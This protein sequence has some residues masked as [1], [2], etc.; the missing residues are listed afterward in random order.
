MD[1]E[2]SRGLSVGLRV[3]GRETVLKILGM[4]CATC[5]L[6]VQKALLSVRG[7]KWAEASL[8]SN[9]AR[10][11][12][13]PEVLDYGELLRAVRRAGYDVYRESAYFVVDFRPEEAESVERR[14]GGWGVFYARAN[15]ATGV[16]YV[17]YNPLEVGADVVVKRLEEAGYRV[18]EVR[19]GGVEVDVDRRVAELEAADLRR[20]LLPAAAA[21]A[22]LVPMMV[23]VELVPPLVQMALAAL[24]QF[25]SGWRFISGA[26]RAFR[27]GTANMDTLVTL[28]TLSAFL[29]SVYAVFAG[30][31]TFFEASALVITFVLAGRYLES[32]MKLRSGDAV[33]RLA[34]L[35]P[36]RARVR[37]GGG[38]VEVDAAEVRPGEVVEVREGERLPV[39][40]YVDEGVG[41]VDESAFT[42]EPLPVEKGP[43]DLVLAGTTLV[44]G[45]LL[46]RATRSGEATYLAEVVKLVRQA[47]NARLPIQNF[48]DRVSGVFTWVVM[49]VASATFVGWLLAGAPVWRAL[50]FAVAVLVVACPCALGLAT[51]LAVVVGIG[52]A[53]ERG[54]LVKNVE[55]V[56]RALGARYVAFDKTGT[57]TVGAPRVVKY[58]GDEWA[59]SLAASAEAKSAHPIAAAVVKFAAE[60]GVAVAEPDMFD[61][62]PGQG[63]YARVNGAVVGVGNEK[64][65]EGLGAELP[66]EI[67]REAEAYRAEG[68]TVA[69]V[70]VDGVVRG[71][72]VV[73]DEV[74]PEAGRILQRLRE[75]GL[76]P[77]IVSGDHVAAV[78]KVA[79]RLGVKRYFGGKT[80]EEKAEVVKELK[81]EGG[82]I[83]IGDG[84]NDAPA[85]ATAD[86]GIAV[87]TGTEVAKEAGDVVVRKG[88]LAKVVEFLELSRKIVRNARFNLFWAFVYNAALIPV[89]AG[90]FYPALYLRPE[91]AG[92][93]M[94]L[95][96]I[97]VTLNALR[98]RRA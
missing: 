90:L 79:E 78:A 97:S 60:R 83:F 54:L 19:R 43:G 21:S 11:V 14:A 73:G 76:E 49:A 95:S 67:R 69:Y 2:F 55:A 24:V 38:W 94:A 62:F 48:V 47:Q 3:E 18:R 89:A 57:L 84:V 56:E 30:G 61:T 5:S 46:V 22:L 40:G 70:V 88:D 41:A 72:L 27:N 44:R 92:L 6:T 64:L 12:V 36:P 7:V 71:Y 26:A 8:A 77:V 25:Y 32:L 75:M 58:V 59:L 9:E 91:L 93:A 65:V 66:L 68:Y 52:R 42:G 82:V 80:P 13:D 35:Q 50:L 10:L 31:P 16:L 20:R 87:A 85:L 39:D 53:A 29:Y 23:G 33:R 74:R 37:R 15:P 86:V 17:E 1:M 63:V 4:H 28:G 96:S 98:L 51:P 34:G 81:K 45:R